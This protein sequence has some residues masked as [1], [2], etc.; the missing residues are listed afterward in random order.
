METRLKKC[1]CDHTQQDNMYGKR[2]RVHNKVTRYSD[3]RWRCT[4]CKRERS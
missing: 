4:V 1:T 2:I 3:V